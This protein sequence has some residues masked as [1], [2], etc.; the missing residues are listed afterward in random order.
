MQER[1]AS[2]FQTFQN[3]SNNITEQLMAMD[4]NERSLRLLVTTNETIPEI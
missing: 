4:V 1:D 3:W 2:R